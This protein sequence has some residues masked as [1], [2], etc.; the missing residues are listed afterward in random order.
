MSLSSDVFREKLIE[1]ILAAS[2]L[3]E[4]NRFINAAMKR[5]EKHKTDRHIIQ[6][7]TEKAAAELALYNPFDTSV[8]EWS[9]IKRAKVILYLISTRMKQPVH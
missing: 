7:C 5:L 8:Q 3:D 2:T 6:Q 9:N 4:V 1:K